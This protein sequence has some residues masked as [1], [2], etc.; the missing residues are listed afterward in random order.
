MVYGP[1]YKN[2]IISD[3]NR[4]YILSNSALETTCPYNSKNNWEYTSGSGDVQIDCL[5]KHTELL[6]SIINYSQ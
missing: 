3:E 5:G 2:W 1:D 4:S 6:K